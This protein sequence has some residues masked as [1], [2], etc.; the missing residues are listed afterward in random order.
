MGIIGDLSILDNS[1][2]PCLWFSF[3]KTD[4]NLSGDIEILGRNKKLRDIIGDSEIKN[5]YNLDKDYVMKFEQIDFT[6][7]KSVK[8]IEF[9]SMLNSFYE[10][11]VYKIDDNLYLLWFSKQIYNDD[12]I[13]KI[14]H[15]TLLNLISDT[16]PDSIFVKDNNGVFIHCNKIFANNRN[17]SKDQVIGKTEEEIN[18]PKEK[19][20][21]YKKEEKEIE[22]VN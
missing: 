1:P 10:I 5:I 15:N 11:D 16:I 2:I 12:V 21:K 6:K 17:L 22:V 7:G 18:T 8:T 9:V 14:S 19:I 13:Q 4:G 3:G 20:E